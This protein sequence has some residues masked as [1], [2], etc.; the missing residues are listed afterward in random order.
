MVTCS[1]FLSN[2]TM[3]HRI[4]KYP[5]E[6]LDVCFKLLS[7]LYCDD[8]G[9]GGHSVHETLD[10]YEISKE[11]MRQG[12]FNLRKWHIN[13]SEL[14]QKITRIEENQKPKAIKKENISEEDESFAKTIIC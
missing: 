12:G 2:A 3:L 11:I 4:K 6:H 13:S 7:A 1:P 10:L 5:D 14:L 9:T 8:V